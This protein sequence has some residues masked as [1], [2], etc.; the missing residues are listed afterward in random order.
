MPFIQ[1]QLRR[2]TSAQWYTANPSL[3]SAE[4]GFESDTKLLKIGDGNTRWA[5]LPYY[6]PSGPAGS[7][8][9]QG[10]T[11][12]AGATGVQGATGPRGTTGPQ[13]D[14]GGPTGVT[15]P[16]GPRGPTGPTGP[17]GPLGPT[18]PTG[19]SG[20]IGITGA[21]GP[22]GLPGPTG[23]MG[24][25][26]ITGPT[27]AVTIYNIYI[28]YNAVSAT[29]AANWAMSSINS[30][31]LPPSITAQITD[32]SPGGGTITLTSTNAAITAPTLYKF[33][34]LVYSRIYAGPGQSTNI[35]TW[36]ASPSWLYSASSTSSPELTLVNSIPTLTFPSGFVVGQAAG[37]NAYTSVLGDGTNIMFAIMSLAFNP[38]II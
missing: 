20:V 10:A 18:G 4:F 37:I 22:I 31:E 16:T 34:P 28:T 32:Y 36:K 14:P 33:M 6:G 24:P 12:I 17:T 21:T 26:G 1:F 13:G 5:Q 2:G 29:A 9:V 7:T 15:G 35:V 38:T 27:G 8:G 19:P 23:V 25:T 11:G 30:S 3:A